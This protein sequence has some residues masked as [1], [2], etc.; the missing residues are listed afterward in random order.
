MYGDWD[1]N[2]NFWLNVMENFFVFNF[3]QVYEG[4][5]QTEATAAITLTEHKEWQTGNII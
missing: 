4:Y 2:G 1:M 3:I 5:G